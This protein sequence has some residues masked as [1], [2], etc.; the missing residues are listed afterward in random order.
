MNDLPGK[1]QLFIVNLGFPGFRLSGSFGPFWTLP[2]LLF[3]NV[4]NLGH[5]VA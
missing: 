3:R 4:D 5:S 1:L 2:D